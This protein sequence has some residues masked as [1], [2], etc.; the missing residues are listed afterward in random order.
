MCALSPISV[1]GIYLQLYSCGR[2]FVFTRISCVVVYMYRCA[3]VHMCACMYV[4][5][6][7]LINL[8]VCSLQLCTMSIQQSWSR[9]LGSL[10]LHGDNKHRAQ[11]LS[12]YGMD[13]LIK[14]I[15]RCIVCIW[16]SKKILHPN[17]A[18]FIK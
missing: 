5:M 8:W 6:H 11:Y 7:V 1:L 17:I 4:C 18:S 16:A 10:I 3:Y 14:C 2:S 13:I 9:W 12:Y 15:K